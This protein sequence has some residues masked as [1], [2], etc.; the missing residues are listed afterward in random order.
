M[1]LKKIKDSLISNILLE[2]HHRNLEYKMG[3]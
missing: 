1:M 3:T 2:N